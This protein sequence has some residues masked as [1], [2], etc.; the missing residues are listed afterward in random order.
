MATSIN[1]RQNQPILFFKIFSSSLRLKDMF[2]V[3]TKADMR[4][5]ACDFVDRWYVF[6]QKGRLRPYAIFGHFLAW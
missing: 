5:T 2:W 6:L 1:P 3:K 4:D